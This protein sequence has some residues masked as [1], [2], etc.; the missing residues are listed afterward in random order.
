MNNNKADNLLLCPIQVSYSADG[1]CAGV[2][3]HP[4]AT[5]KQDTPLGPV[6]VCNT[7]YQG[8]GRKC[9]DVDECATDDDDQPCHVEADCVNTV[10]SFNCSCKLGF[11]GDGFLCKPDGTCRGIVCAVDADCV[12]S[13]SGDQICE[14]K[15]GFSGDGRYCRDIDE[16][17]Q[18]THKC[19]RKS[20]CVNRPGTYLC[21]CK[22]GY[23]GNGFNCSSDG[24]CEGV[25]CDF[26][27]D[28]V[29][30][31]NS[32]DPEKECQCKPGY[33]GEGVICNDIN[34]CLDKSVCPDK[35]DCF[36][37]DGSFMC[38]CLPGYKMV[39]KSCRKDCNL[40]QNGGSC[41]ENNTCLCPPGFSGSRCQWHGEASLIFS[42]GNSIQR[43]SLPPR[44]NNIGVI[45]QRAGAVHV[46]VDY[47]CVESRVYWTEVTK[48]VIV[49]A[50]YDGSDMEVIV[51]SGEI[52]SPEGIAVD[53]LGRNIYWT[54]SW[55]DAIE[56]AKLNGSHRRTL[57][58]SDLVDPRAIIVDPP[59]GKMYW[60]DW[61]RNRP[62]IEVANMDG[63][64][65][66]VLVT[67]PLS[68]PNGLTLVHSTNELC[69]SDAGMWAISCVNLGDL[70]MRKAYHP[71]PYPFGITSF[72]RTLFWTDWKLGRIQRMGMNSKIPD[73]PLRSFVGSSGKIFDI[74][75]VQP[76]GRTAA[77][78]K[79]PCAAKNG[80]CLG[81]C[82]LKSKS[83]SCSCPDGLHLVRTVNG[84]KCQEKCNGALGMESG[85]IMDQQLSAHSAWNDNRARY[86]ASRA[87]LYQNEWPQGWSAQKNDPSPWL[88]IDLLLDRTVTAVATQGYGNKKE[89]EWVKTYVLMTS[90]DG[91]R[92]NAY[93]EGGRKRIF[94]GNV[95]TGSVVRNELK[96]PLRTRWLRI[97]PRSWNNNVGMR[98]ELYGC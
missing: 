3:C 33:A 68:L 12:T 65:R 73:K 89:K 35:A 15:S 10:G 84:T 50:R 60:A 80:G 21:R 40:C 87:R 88:Q 37:L 19:H 32:A 49:R 66:R 53:W 11:E 91:E 22:P 30:L 71:A 8:D 29:T 55:L 27:A 56:V 94:I 83:Y 6:C 44:P 31:N 52:A 34:E 46:G 38:H 79:N 5:C 90:R 48:G 41:T 28:C 17:A 62:K 42:K 98:V 54:D 23:F 85:F 76:C 77:A 36:N 43:M 82:L 9:T 2:R 93:R 59:N 45:Y 14:C 74:K 69:Y 70:S 20:T 1:T 96:M 26:N 61:S 64:D 95:D 57:I 81:L 63:T 24:T 25:V 72:N 97:V 78:V 47:D 92:W 16:C 18:L 39:G 13:S 7:G 86:G 4:D 75:A 58:S 67:S 51:N